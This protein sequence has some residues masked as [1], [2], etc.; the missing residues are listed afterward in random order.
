MCVLYMSNCHAGITKYIFGIM[1]TTRECSSHSVY[2]YS[3]PANYSDIR[4][5]NEFI[6]FEF[7]CPF[8]TMNYIQHTVK[9]SFNSNFTYI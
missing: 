3:G 2:N 6:D 9:V 8:C 1:D 7:A 4:F 5:L